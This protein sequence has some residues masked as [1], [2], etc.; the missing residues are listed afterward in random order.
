MEQDILKTID[1]TLLNPV[2]T[3]SMVQKLCDEA[4]AFGCASVC[5]PPTFVREAKAY[6]K[7]KIPVCTVIGFPN[8]YQRAEVKAYETKLAVE[9][10]ADEIDLVLN[11]G[12]VRE[13]RYEALLAEIEEVRKVCA[14]Q[15]LKVIVET[16]YWNREEKIALCQLLNASSADFIKTSTGFAAGGATLDDVVLF[17]EY[18]RPSL[19]IKAAGGIRTVEQA[20]AFLAAGASRLGASS[21]AAAIAKKP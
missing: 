6:V 12:L 11:L 1:H 5:I 17:K 14:E 21:L 3:W 16:C 19:Q 7:E 10:G 2:A 13:H 4:I 9:D 8:G 18:I 15:V 20:K